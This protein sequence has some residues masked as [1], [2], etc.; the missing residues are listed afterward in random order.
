MNQVLILSYRVKIVKVT[1]IL[2]LG[3]NYHLAQDIQY[4]QINYS[5]NNNNNNKLLKISSKVWK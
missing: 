1:L 2:D 4:H 5:S 3:D